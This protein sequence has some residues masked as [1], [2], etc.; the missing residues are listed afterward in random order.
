MKNVPLLDLEI[1]ECGPAP[2]CSLNFKSRKAAGG[3]PLGRCRPRSV[4]KK[5]EYGIPK[6]KCD[7]ICFF[8]GRRSPCRSGASPHQE[9]KGWGVKQEICRHAA[10]H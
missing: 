9:Y 5:K 3:A 10:S 6:G 4:A 8:S 1:M 2:S 7:T